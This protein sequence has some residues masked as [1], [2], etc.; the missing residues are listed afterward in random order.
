M[1]NVTD[2]DKNL[3]VETDIVRD[4]LV[5]KSALDESFKLYGIY[6]DTK[7][8][9]RLPDDVASN[10]SPAV[11]KLATNTAGGR[12]R[13]VTNSPYI[14]I[15][16]K[17]PHNTLFAHMTLT[18]IA[19]FDM[20][21]YEN[22][23]YTIAKSFIPYHS[24]TDSYE[25]VHDFSSG[26]KERDLTINF[27][28]YNDVYEL[29]IGYKEG[30]V[31]KAPAEYK[32]DKPIVFYGSSITQG[33]CA[34]RPGNAYTAIIAR[35][36]DADHINLGFSGSAKGEAAMVDYIAGLDMSLFVL[37]YDHN[38]DTNLQYE[39]THEPLFKSVRANHPDLP[40]VIMTRPKYR[41]KLSDAEFKRIDI[42]KRT[43]DNAVA[44]GDKNV[45]FIPGYELMEFAGE[46][47]CVDFTHP[48]DYGFFSMAKRLSE[49]L[50]KIL[51]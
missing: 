14:V 8:F 1:S 3:K 43:Y 47:G 37:D 49:E 2:I 29:Y 38:A 16:V 4:G 25:S 33:G 20:Y 31:F 51:K 9:R 44:S 21:E 27:P 13:F 15:K 35:K 42:A 45:Y 28:L 48:T 40:I 22:G 32:Y 46:D 12:L 7:Q 26:D 36:Y 5:F 10:T 50:D 41:K 19:G 34:S 18:G 23:T 39:A 6:H 17:L 24:F 11:K 30:S